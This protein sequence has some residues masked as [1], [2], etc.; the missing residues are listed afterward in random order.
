MH[1]LISLHQ[2]LLQIQNF[3]LLVCYVAR[4]RPSGRQ[5]VSRHWPQFQNKNGM[6]GSV[7]ESYPP[8]SAKSHMLTSL[9]AAICVYRDR[10][11]KLPPAF[12]TEVTV[13]HASNFMCADHT[14]AYKVPQPADGGRSRGGGGEGVACWCHRMIT[15][16]SMPTTR[17]AIST[18]PAQPH[19]R[20]APPHRRFVR[21][22]LPL[23]G[24]DS[25]S[26][27]VSD[28]SLPPIWCLRSCRY[29]HSSTADPSQLLA[30][31]TQHVRV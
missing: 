21:A 30:Y 6:L 1:H 16:V 13:Q 4:K 17:I 24:P 27:G 26:N 9:I 28:T 19:L 8:K 11:Q 18:P 7:S 3:L 14:A 31:S 12:Q 29:L 15:I 20:P 23:L 22:L 2:Q 25:M 10:T 5:C